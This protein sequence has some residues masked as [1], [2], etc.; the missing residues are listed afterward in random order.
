M[1]LQLGTD[2]AFALNDWSFSQLCKLAGVA[3]DTVN[4]LSSETAGRVLQETLPGGRKPLQLLTTDRHVRSVHS[5]S[6]SRLWNVELVELLQEAATDFTPPQKAMTG[7]TGLYSGEQDL[8]CFMIDPTGWTEINGEAFAPGFFVWNSEVG[9]RSVGIST[10]WFQAVCRNH[11]VW[12]VT[13]VTEF[14]RKHTGNVT[15]ALTDIRQRVEDLVRLRDTRR[16]GFVTVVRRAMETKLGDD[17]D[18][19][20]K[21]LLREGIPRSLSQQALNI[22]SQ[23]GRFTLWSLIDAL[24]RLN[25]NLRYAGD[26]TDADAK[27]SSLLA[28]AV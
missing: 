9:R 23:Q 18:E 13:E 22:A 14:T 12:D 19:V 4:R 28:L 20:L 26:R 17:A 15:D 16:D 8:F 5:A 25:G 1:S 21:V 3:K 24:T 2:G 6:Y 7:G 27:F 10:F 11:I